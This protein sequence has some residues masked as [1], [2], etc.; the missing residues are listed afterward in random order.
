VAR[1]KSPRL[2]WYEGLEGP[3]SDRGALVFWGWWSAVMGPLH[4]LRR[5]AAGPPCSQH[6]RVQLLPEKSGRMRKADRGLRRGNRR[7]AMTWTGPR[8]A[9]GN[10][11]RGHASESRDRVARVRPALRRP[12]RPCRSL[13]PGNA[14]LR[15]QSLRCRRGHSQSSSRVRK[16]G[17]NSGA[18]PSSPP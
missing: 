16:A 18:G 9:P 5:S 15:T 1:S 11:G 4:R 12:R 13:S 3:A 14:G 8:P 17:A 2:E 6:G 7:L 10:G